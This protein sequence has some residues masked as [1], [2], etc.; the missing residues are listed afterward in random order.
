MP[1]PQ[2]LT[3]PTIKIDM[4]TDWW[5]QLIKILFNKLMLA[6]SR[7]TEPTSSKIESQEDEADEISPPANRHAAADSQKTHKPHGSKQIVKRLTNHMVPKEHM[8]K[9]LPDRYLLG[10][11]PTQ[12]IGIVSHKVAIEFSKN[13]FE[14]INL[15]VESEQLDPY[16]DRQLMRIDRSRGLHHT[17][18]M[19]NGSGIETYETLQM[20][21]DT[22]IRLCATL[23]DNYQLKQSCE[24]SL[25][26]AVA[27]FR[28]TLR[29][30]EVQR[31][32]AKNFQRA[33]KL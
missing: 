24:C 32:I 12:I 18:Q 7:R 4:S 14:I 15:L 3:Q 23:R 5:D 8:K 22:F 11:D 13:V 31:E 9:N 16:G 19:I 17:M 30:D 29:H 20:K 25:E 6:S 10:K 1:S 27:M 28:K 2:D 21:H 33:K 26:E